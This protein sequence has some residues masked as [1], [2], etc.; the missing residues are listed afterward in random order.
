MPSKTVGYIYPTTDYPI[1]RIFQLLEFSTV[2][3][4]LICTEKIKFFSNRLWS[5][6][7][8]NTCSIRKS[9]TKRLFHLVELKN[10]KLFPRAIWTHLGDHIYPNFI[11]LLKF[12]S[13]LLIL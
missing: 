2:G 6:I 9:R 3:R 10:S 8:K 12:V 4:M 7:N 5:C 11:G 1:L 13:D